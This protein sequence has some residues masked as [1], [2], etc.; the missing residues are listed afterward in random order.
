[1]NTR[2]TERLRAGQYALG[3]H[4]TLLDSA[5]T[6]LLGSIGFDYLWIDTEHTAIGLERLQQHLIAARAA[7]VPAI[8]RIPWVDPVLAKPVL[9]MGPDG[10]VFPQVRSY[11]DARRAVSSVLYPPKGDRGFGPR[12]ATLYGQTP[13]HAYMEFAERYLLKVVQIEHIGAVEDLDRILTIDEIDAYVLGPCDLSASMHML[14]RFEDD[15][16]IATVEEVSRKVRAA[17]KVMGLSYVITSA[18]ELALWRARGIQMIS[19]GMDTDYL[20]RG[21]AATLSDLHGVFYG[22]ETK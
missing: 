13:L 12:R 6:E 17:G 4:V 3:T 8:V 10:I 19:I 7:G 2:L 21:G 9:D 20:L 1:M 14:N 18:E 16:F 11:E 5:V 15:R 22:E